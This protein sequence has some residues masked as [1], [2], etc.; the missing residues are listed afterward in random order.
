M[1]VDEVTMELYAGSGGD[2][3]TS[4]RREKFIPL[5]GPNGGNGGKGADIIFK[6][7][8][9]LRTLIDLRYQK[10]I[11][12]K[13]GN[14][15]EGKAMN[16]ANSM[17]VKPLNHFRFWC[18]KVL[19]L[20]YDDSLSYYEV[21]CKVVNYINNL[22][23]TNNQ[24]IEY[25]DELKAELKVVQDWIDNFDT[26]YAESIIREYL[27]TM[28]FVEISD[29]GYFVYYIPESWDDITFNT[30]GLDITIPDTDYGRLVLSY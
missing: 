6:A 29:A 19:P 14:N 8:E 27:A 2:G 11:K 20:V 24:I 25:V 3:C 15:G 16:G 21:L 13:N 26:S 18:Q 10:K 23:D 17:D 7:D 1:F 28:I 22:I 12:G 9:G 5:G 4:F 30:T